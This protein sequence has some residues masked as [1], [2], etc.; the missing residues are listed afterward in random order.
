[1]QRVFDLHDDR[2]DP[3]WSYRTVQA[4]RADDLLAQLRRP[5]LEQRP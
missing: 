3:W 1:M 2:D 5:F 4:Q